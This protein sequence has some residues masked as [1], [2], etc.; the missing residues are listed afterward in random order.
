MASAALDLVINLKGDADKQIGGLSKSILGLGKSAVGVGATISKAIGGIVLGGA[1][2][3]VAGLGAAL[4]GGIS[5]AREAAKVF[6]QTEAVLKSTGGASGK[7]AEQISE[8]AASLSAA[9][10]ASL[11]GDDL[12]Q[13][14]SN[15]LLTFTNLKGPIVDAATAISVDM[16]QALGGAPA[17]AAVQLG[18]ALQDPI[19]GISALTR[20][21]VTFSDEQKKVIASLVETG[22]MAGAQQIIL[23]ELNKEF[24]GSAAAAAAADGGFAQFQDRMGELAESVGTMVLPALNSLMG[25]LNSP[26]VQ[27]GITGIVDGIVAAGAAF[28]SFVQYIAAVVEDGDTLNDFLMGLPEPLR[29][30]T[31]VLGEVANAITTGLGVA[32]TWLTTTALPALQTAFNLARDGILT[33]IAA[34]QGDWQNS[35]KILLIHQ[36]FGTLGTIIGTV[37]VPAIQS[38]VGWFQQ[39]WD[40]ISKV[41]IAIGVAV[42]VFQTL[43]TVAAIVATVT[44]A[45][46]GM[47]TAITVAGGTVAV[48][49]AALGGPLTI[50]L[51]AVALAVGAL[52]LAWQ[53]NFGGIQEKTAT[54]V[55]WW[56]GTAQPAIVTAFNTVVTQVGVMKTAWDRDFEAVRGF[57]TT[58]QEAWDTATTAIGVAIDLVKGYVSSMRDTISTKIDEAVTFFT[59]LPGRI[60][61]AL[62]NLGSLLVQAGKDVINGLIEGL[63]SIDVGSILGGILT[64]AI[65]AAKAAAGIGSPSKMTRDDLGIPLIQGIIEGIE[66]TG[67]GLKQAVGNTVIDAL[68]QTSALVDPYIATLGSGMIQS[69]IDGMRPLLDDLARYS[70]PDLIDSVV[71]ALQTGHV[72]VGQEGE[73]LAHLLMGPIERLR[74]QGHYVGEDF[75]ASLVRALAT[76]R[77]EAG[78]EGEEL[79]RA[80]LEGVQTTLLGDTLAFAAQSLAQQAADAAVAIAVAASAKLAEAMEAAQKATTDSARKTAAAAVEAARKAAEEAMDAAAAATDAIGRKVL[81]SLFAMGSAFG[82][83]GNFAAGLF[84]KQ[85]LDPVTGRLK[86]IADELKEIDKQARELTIDGE[87]LS[88][89]AEGERLEARKAELLR[90]QTR[91]KEKQAVLEARLLKLQEQQQMLGWLQQQQKLLDLISQFGLD[92]SVILGDLKLGI[93]ASIEGIMEAMQR[94]MAAVLAQINERMGGGATGTGEGKVTNTASMPNLMTMPAMVPVGI[95]PSRAGVSNIYTTAIEEGAIVIVQQPGQD[96]RQLAREVIYEMDREMERRR[97]R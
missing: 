69:M 82:S 80:I 8:L 13:Q 29:G 40:I 64:G 97:N 85:Q 34:F 56:T 36:V 63:R 95:G 61:S 55:T 6:A 30:V 79:A 28:G 42:A 92:P 71:D 60:T 72:K 39:N 16:A 15:L 88:D 26:E 96:A 91:E 23:A 70:G 58:M 89:T 10:G 86:A 62:G 68:D 73:E 33:F 20:V 90:E 83:I 4:V 75:L 45:V 3:G 94:A 2:A 41:G 37:V 53:T 7:T 9:S 59:E 67:D 25:W 65:D 47:G 78:Q 57:I 31:M 12:I 38:M 50:A 1:I 52:A 17:D 19:K 54:V 76:G 74:E 87:L 22:D 21:G 51:A 46:A 24:G 27:A 81:D 32:F 84:K 49:V 77:I 35:D 11:F 66:A 48:I 43:S 93:G 5:D 44:A 18:K 14:S